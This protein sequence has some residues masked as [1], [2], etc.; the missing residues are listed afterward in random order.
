MSTEALL[1]TV[2]IDQLM[3]RYNQSIDYGDP[4]AFAACF[5]PDGVLEFPGQRI[6]GTA[7]IREFCTSVPT[8][9]PGLKHWTS[10]HQIDVHGDTAS[11]LVHLLM[12]VVGAEGTNVIGHGRYADQLVRTADGWR[13]ASRFMT[14]DAALP[15]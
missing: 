13:Y 4:D 15:G 6:E 3:A 11:A 5:V 14:P 2:A 8:M 9:V 10:N 7:A 12:V 1:D